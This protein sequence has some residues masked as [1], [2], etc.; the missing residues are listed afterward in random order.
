MAH[1]T[2]RQR[3][4][5]KVLRMGWGD[6]AGF[7][8]LDI[9][10]FEGPMRASTSPVPGSLERLQIS[11]SAMRHVPTQQCIGHHPPCTSSTLS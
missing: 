1:S 8:P 9:I 2:R 3:R 5:A 4:E 7:V 6:I 10:Q 11:E